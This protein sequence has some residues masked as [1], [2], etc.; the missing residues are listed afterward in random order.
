MVPVAD[1]SPFTASWKATKKNDQVSDKKVIGVCSFEVAS[2][3]SKMIQL[4]NFLNDDVDISQVSESV[5]IEKLLKD[6]N[7]GILD[8][9]YGEVMYIF[10]QAA[11]ILVRL[12]KNCSDARL[13][14]LEH[15][16]EGQLLRMKN[17][18][19]LPFS[20]K[21]MEENIKKM[22][23]L[24]TDNEKL[25]AEMQNIRKLEKELVGKSTVQRLLQLETNIEAKEL[26][27]S[28]LKRPLWD[29]N[30]DDIVFILS[31][32][33]FTTFVRIESLFNVVHVPDDV[34][35][36]KLVRGQTTEKSPAKRLARV[37]S[38]SKGNR[39][40]GTIESFAR[41][42]ADHSVTRKNKISLSILKTR[43]QSPSFG[44]LGDAK[45][46]QTYA[47]AILEIDT[48]V[49]L[50]NMITEAKIRELKKMLP[51][52][53]SFIVKERLKLVGNE[54]KLSVSLDMISQ[55]L[56]WLTPLAHNTLTRWMSE[57][58]YA[59]QNINDSGEKLLL[60]VET[61]C[62]ADKEKADAVVS[63]LLIGL[64]HIYL[65]QKQ[66]SDCSSEVSGRD[67]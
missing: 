51:R 66:L 46:E 67:K 58:K 56:D 61:L 33:L 41:C 52:K 3:M 11:R 12:A 28:H 45:L 8:L 43:L 27:V 22:E 60:Q 42:I 25:Y 2:L 55:I 16:I 49:M 63:E 4:W 34:K 30:Y 10:C 29:T 64:T 36:L 7:D 48:L 24:I 13:Q 26:E 65:G 14:N 21:K 31:K 19:I 5:G 32:C 20:H 62:F 17:S 37:G 18:W 38:Y 50:P 54:E 40:T 6:N 23:D 9:I 57:Q 15:E 1:F 53:I 44:T 59:H 39:K 47:N 35:S